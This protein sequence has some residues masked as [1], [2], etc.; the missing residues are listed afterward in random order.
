MEKIQFGQNERSAVIKKPGVVIGQ[1]RKESEMLDRDGNVIDPRTK[2]VIR[3][4]DN[5]NI[6]RE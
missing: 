6:L 2:Q 4:R 5:E 1:L 3:P